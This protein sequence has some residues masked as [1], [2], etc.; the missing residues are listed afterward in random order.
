MGGI[1]DTHLFLFITHHFIYNRRGTI[2]FHIEI[3]C[4]KLKYVW[5]FIGSL[6]PGLHSGVLS[7]KKKEI[8]I[9]CI[10][11]QAAFGPMVCA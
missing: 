10:E 4:Q 11:H 7:M 1:V 8:A 3:H 6:L 5:Y 9:F 2:R